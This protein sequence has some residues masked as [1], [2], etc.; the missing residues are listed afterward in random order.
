MRHKETCKWLASTCI[1]FLFRLR[2][3]YQ[4]GLYAN[5]DWQCRCRRHTT[6]TAII[7]KNAHLQ[8]Q[9]LITGIGKREREKTQRQQIQTKKLSSFEII[10]T[11]VLLQ[12]SIFFSIFFFNEKIEFCYFFN[13][14]S[15]YGFE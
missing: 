10:E 12:I 1:G 11:K 14:N 5:F 2:C 9:F 4:I 3:E 15:N 6:P 8:R 13:K 7:T